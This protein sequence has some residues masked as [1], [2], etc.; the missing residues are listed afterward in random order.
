MTE[1]QLAGTK[2]GVEAQKVYDAVLKDWK[3]DEQ[4]PAKDTVAKHKYGKTD[5]EVP[6]LSLG[7]F[8]S[9]AVTMMHNRKLRCLTCCRCKAAIYLGVHAF[10]MP[11]ALL[12]GAHTTTQ[13]PRCAQ[14]S[15]P[16]PPAWTLRPP[17]AHS[18]VRCDRPRRIENSAA[19]DGRAVHDAVRRGR[20]V[21]VAQPRAVAR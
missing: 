15:P 17:C 2:M 13:Q 20:A 10:L 14:P 3:L 8:F 6:V 21:G 11:I 19:G 4:D 7:G 1:E 16:G 5:I 9:L 18:S 12:I